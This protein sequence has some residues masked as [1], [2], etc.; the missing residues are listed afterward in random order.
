MLNMLRDLKYAVRT[1]SKNYG[2]TAAASLMLAFGL[3]LVLFMFG[4]VKGF[5]L[6][7][8]PFVEPERIM[9]VEAANPKLDRNS[10]EINWFDY[11]E[12][13][14]SQRSFEDLAA[15]SGGTINMSADE[16]PERYDGIFI[17]A[18][19]FDVLKVKPV[20]GRG[21]LPGEDVAGAALPVLIGDNLWRNRFNADPGVIGKAVRVNGRDAT[22]VGVMAPGFKFPIN[23]NIWI[24][25]QRPVTDTRADTITVEVYGRLK[26]G[27]DVP[28]AKQDL[29]AILD[30]LAKD[31]P[32][33]NLDLIPVVKPYKDEYVG[34]VTRKI[35]LTMFAAVLLVLLIA[36]ANVANLILARSTDR[37]RELAVRTA[38][39]ASRWQIVRAMLAE[40]LVIAFIGAGIGL[41]IAH[42]GIE[43]LD[44]ALVANDNSAPY[45]VDF[46]VDWRVGAFAFVIAVVT[47]FIA[48]LLPALR[49]SR[50]DVHDVLKDAG[51]G[52]AGRGLTRLTRMLV[53]GE[54]ALSC[55]LLVAAGLTVRSTLKATELDI[56][57]DI[58]SVLTGRIGLFDEV[59][60]TLEARQQFY[61]KLEARLAEIPGARSVAIT[62]SLP[63]TF[64]GGTAVLPEGKAP[65]DKPSGYLFTGRIVS[66]PGMFET[67]GIQV[68]EG[69]GFTA[70]DRADSGLVAIV[71][72][73][74]VETYFKDRPAVG[75]HFK[76]DA[77]DPE[78]ARDVTIIGVVNH[79]RHEGG[80][81][82]D[83]DPV[84]YIPLAQDDLK[85]ASFAI[86]TD[87]D[88]YALSA[89]A[90]E[91]VQAVDAD[92]PIYWL[93]SLDDWLS[94]ALFDHRLL[95][96]LFGIFALFALLLA[97]AGIYA[98]LAFA[99][100]TRTREIGVRR[101]LGA[102][103]QGILRMVLGQGLRQLALGLGI[104]LV[105]AV[106]FAQ[107]MTSFLLDI[108]TYDPVTYL[109]VLGTLGAVTALACTVPA[110][111]ALKIDPMVALRY[112]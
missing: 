15:W 44:R 112:E 69:R 70:A 103:D 35:I 27:V 74:F 71:N 50:L 55:V 14:R 23:N 30:Q 20:L 39:G 6:I 36:C 94:R 54:I 28:Q 61:Q 7:Q 62:S 110:L 16:Q 89:A 11:L 95:G 80:D 72:P 42:F 68:R 81:L 9:H 47:A 67:L 3:G 26:P 43:A 5:F 21:F 97:A 76:I 104:G 57:A 33:T 1:L 79:V 90:R 73:T 98:V 66:T 34:D 83:M 64:M 2:F 56:G 109:V 46:S 92:L 82:T 37:T 52:S 53:I 19:G 77:T 78:R 105:L 93:R 100:G 84:V 40:S 22:I 106:G 86:K 101:A 111:R 25:Q 41:L 99:V 88:P 58:S 107:A 32:D 4:A 48:G 29:G 13:K 60:P 85:F 87:G 12:M 65:P 102:Q 18:N 96:T 8:L 24:P 38:L 17:T 75:G 108:P 91:A 63:L 59:Y 51:R 45:F 49:A 10:L 31:F